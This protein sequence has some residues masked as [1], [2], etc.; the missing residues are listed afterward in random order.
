MVKKNMAKKEKKT[1]WVQIIIIFLAVLFFVLW[2]NTK[3]N[4]QEEVILKNSY[5]QKLDSCEKNLEVQRNICSNSLEY[6]ED[7]CE[8]SRLEFL[9]ENDCWK[10]G[11]VKCYNSNSSVYCYDEPKITHS[12]DPGYRLVCAKD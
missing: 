10:R 9:A 5:E 12:C 4:Y 6:S 2:I 1:D 3:S 11:S 8:K 7:I